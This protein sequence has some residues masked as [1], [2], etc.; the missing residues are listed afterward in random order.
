[1]YSTSNHAPALLEN[2][3][4]FLVS[5]IP[6]GNKILSIFLVPNEVILVEAD[7]DTWISRPKDRSAKIEGPESG[8]HVLAK[9]TNHVL[10]THVGAS[11]QHVIKELVTSQ[12]FKSSLALYSILLS[13]TSRP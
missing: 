12:P 3:S 6:F 7:P 13:S 11:H 10:Y 5:A 9:S 4:A 2:A 8:D 1:M